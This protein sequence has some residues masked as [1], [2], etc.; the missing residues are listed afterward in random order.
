MAIVYVSPGLATG[1][2]DGTTGA[3]AFRSW[4]AF[5]TAGCAAGSDVR[6]N[7][8]ENST[9]AVNLTANI[10]GTAAG[11]TTIT[12]YS[13]DWTTPTV[14]FRNGAGAGANIDGLILNAV[15]F[16]YFKKIQIKNYTRDGVRGVTAASP[17]NV[18]EDC[19]FNNNTSV[20][21][22]NQASTAGVQGAFIDCYFGENGLHGYQAS[23]TQIPLFV[24]CLFR[25]NTTSNY[26]G[27]VVGVRFT[28]CIFIGSATGII[29][30]GANSFFNSG[31][32]NGAT[33]VGYSGASVSG[34]VLRNTIIS[35]C[36]KA[37]AMTTGNVILANTST[38]N[39]T[40][41]NTVTTGSITEIDCT[42]LASDP[43]VNAAAGNFALKNTVVKRWVATNIGTESTT[44]FGMTPGLTPIPDFPVV[45]K[46]MAD[47][48]VDLATGTLALANVLVGAGGTFD[49]AARNTD[50][51]I[52]N[53][54]L[55]TTYKI[56]NTSLVGTLS[57][58][59]LVK[60]ATP[61]NLRASIT[62]STFIELAWDM[63]PVTGGPA[64]TYETEIDGVVFTGIVGLTK[65]YA[66]LTPVTDYSFRVRAKNDA[67]YS[68][69]S[70]AL[71]VLTEQE[72]SIVGLITRNIVS[73]LA[74][75]TTANGYKTNV[76]ACEQE[77]ATEHIAGRLP[78]I[79]VC[80]PHVSIEQAQHTQGDKYNLEYTA[81]YSALL[82]DNLIAD[83]PVS[84]Q[85]ENV[86]A[87]MVKAL[88]VDF[89]RNDLAHITKP[90]NIYHTLDESKGG[91]MFKVVLE[92]TVETFVDIY[93]P[94]LQG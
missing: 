64:A 70:A 40:N 13:T 51:G 4:A 73:S 78:M 39:N 93:S 11:Y 83:E 90:T 46:V 80:G 44:Q 21:F 26:T 59:S 76:I 42:V 35:N 25:N 89:R 32:I 79:E 58:G 2:N 41:A 66:D 56:Q 48:T 91:F 47:D 87:D 45:S 17:F 63:S 3:D 74:L 7:A 61:T 53:V 67:G 6:V 54:R 82:N 77:R 62:S 71:V 9:D 65:R 94:Y 22:N 81:I 38:Y 50:P 60:P 10:A 57:A 31:I 36:A 12:G 29:N 5:A 88:M 1:N 15:T 84:A 23:N 33:T 18:F 75:I 37:V 68:D 69:W 20:G 34:T 27:A 30:T 52:A 43:F 85:V 49:E 92:F 86:G 8:D 14:R 28:D 19:L 16:V 24:R 55:D 72:R